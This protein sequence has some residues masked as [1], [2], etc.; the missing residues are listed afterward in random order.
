M[1]EPIE[2]VLSG[3]KDAGEAAV[4]GVKYINRRIHD[5]DGKTDACIDAVVKSK[6]TLLWVAVALLL[7]DWLILWLFG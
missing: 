6:R 7:N 5:L 4:R 2:K 1:L 3:A